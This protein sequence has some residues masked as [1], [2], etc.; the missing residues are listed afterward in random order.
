MMI[1]DMNKVPLHC[2]VVAP[3]QVYESSF[4]TSKDVYETSHNP[5]WLIGADVAKSW[6][7]PHVG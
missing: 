2:T 4:W 5:P 7:E 3:R 6:E 1:Q